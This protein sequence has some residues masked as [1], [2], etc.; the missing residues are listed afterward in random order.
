MVIIYLKVISWWRRGALKREEAKRRH[1]FQRQTQTP[2][3]ANQAP[4][5]A[6]GGLAVLIFVHAIRELPRGRSVSHLA[7]QCGSDFHRV[8]FESSELSTNVILHIPVEESALQL[9]LLSGVDE[10]LFSANIS[11]P[12]ISRSSD[13]F[14]SPRW[15]S[16]SLGPGQVSASVIKLQFRDL[17]G[18]IARFKVSKQALLDSEILFGE[19]AGRAEDILTSMGNHEH[20][21]LKLSAREGEAQYLGRLLQLIKLIADKSRQAHMQPAAEQSRQLQQLEHE[22]AALR[23]QVEALISVRNAQSVLSKRSDE[24]EVS[25]KTAP[26]PMSD[27][28]NPYLL[29]LQSAEQRLELLLRKENQA[30]SMLE[31][32]NHQ[33]AD[34]REQLECSEDGKDSKI[35]ELKRALSIASE[36]NKEHASALSIAAKKIIGLEDSLK[37]YKHTVKDVAKSLGV[38]LNS[39]VTDPITKDELEAL[40]AS[41]VDA[42]QDAPDAVFTLRISERINSVALF[43]DRELQLALGD[44]SPKIREEL[45]KIPSFEEYFLRHARS[46]S[47]LHSDSRRLLVSVEEACANFELEFSTIIPDEI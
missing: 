9:R 26:K 19:Y 10:E 31:Q 22:N 23:E 40:H 30:M 2:I 35:Y 24:V 36:L 7:V 20:K 47:V 37:M 18:V 34:L 28:H 1:N 29:Q 6:K 38:T 15:Y 46:G 43:L 25:V 12:S 16:S 4:F 41:A 39:L 11:L 13:A 21:D 5:S 27:E 44:V 8:S 14:D 45:K 33:V 3:F 17:A 32:A 42:T